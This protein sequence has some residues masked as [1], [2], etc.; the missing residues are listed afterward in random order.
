[1]CVY[2]LSE[3]KVKDGS[4]VGFDGYLFRRVFVSLELQ[5]DVELT[6]FKYG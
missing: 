2:N 3:D 5:G 4:L 1:M 6:D